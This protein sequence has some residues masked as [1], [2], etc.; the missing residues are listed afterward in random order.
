MFSYFLC[1]RFLK[2]NYFSE[3]LKHFKFS[4]HFKPKSLKISRHN[5]T[6]SFSFISYSSINLKIKTTFQISLKYTCSFLESP[7]YR[8]SWNVR[9]PYIILHKI[10]SR[11]CWNLLNLREHFCSKTLKHTEHSNSS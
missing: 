5:F 4:F 9:M 6:R 1:W 10:Y 2:K 8:I 7:F 3:L 11:K